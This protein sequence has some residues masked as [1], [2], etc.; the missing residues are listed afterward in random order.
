[1]ILLNVN[2]IVFNCLIQVMILVFIINEINDP[3]AL[4]WLQVFCWQKQF[5]TCLNSDPQVRKYQSRI[6]RCAHVDIYICLWKKRLIPSENLWK[7]WIH[8]WRCNV[9]MTVLPSF[10]PDVQITCDTEF[11]PLFK[12]FVFLWKY[13]VHMWNCEA[14]E[15]KRDENLV[16]KGRL[17]LSKIFF[18]FCCKFKYDC[19]PAS[20]SFKFL[21]HLTWW[22]SKNI[23]AQLWY[24]R[25]GSISQHVRQQ[26]ASWH[27]NPLLATR[28]SD[29]LLG[30]QV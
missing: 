12:C 13:S 14:G 6:N 9:N 15:D 5:Q 17:F 20:M 7:S 22:Y 18:F 1:M 21:P 11:F 25:S 8:V 16:W 2:I 10:G 27:L 19:K 4:Y 3:H 29:R 23:L 30:D 28:L 26:T 24:S